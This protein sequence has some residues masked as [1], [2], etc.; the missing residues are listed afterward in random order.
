MHLLWSR[1]FPL[2]EHWVMNMGGGL[3]NGK[4]MIFSEFFLAVVIGSIPY[5]VVITKFGEL[6][7]FYFIEEMLTWTYVKW[8]LLCFLGVLPP[9]INYSGCLQQAMGQGEYGWTRTPGQGY[10]PAEYGEDTKDE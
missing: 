6:M 5:L 3:V 1:V 2:S 4:G 8:P 9:I 10:D 7:K